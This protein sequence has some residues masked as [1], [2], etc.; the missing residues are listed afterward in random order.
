MGKP[1][2]TT[3]E[4]QAELGTLQTGIQDYSLLKN[5]LTGLT[6]EAIIAQQ[7]TVDTFF[8]ATK[9]T[10]LNDVT[11]SN[12]TDVYDAEYKKVKDVRFTLDKTTDNN[13]AFYVFDSATEAKKT[14]E[15]KLEAEVKAKEDYAAQQERIKKYVEGVQNTTTQKVFNS[16]L[17]SVLD[18]SYSDLQKGFITSDSP[19]F[20]RT[21]FN[22][23]SNK[24]KDTKNVWV[25]DSRGVRRLQTIYM[26]RDEAASKLQL[27]TVTSLYQEKF[28][29][30]TNLQKTW[31]DKLLKPMNDRVNKITTELKKRN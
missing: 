20:N 5:K 2:H 13:A 18:E 25:T 28:N 6:P 31:L 16:Y 9:E 4:L 22:K 19:L 15:Q 3:A 30:D 17:Q 27:N 1:K 10:K 23:A 24:N 14:T 8:N 29:S 21:A 7:P 11:A 26:Y 12:Y